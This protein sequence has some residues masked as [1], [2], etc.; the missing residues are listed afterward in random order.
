MVQIHGDEGV[1][2]HIG[3]EPCGVIREDDIESSV[4]EH[5]GQP[6]SREIHEIRVPTQFCWR[7][8]TRTG[9]SSR[10]PAATR[11][12]RRPWHAW[13]L[14]IREPGGLIADH[15]WFAVPGPHR[16]GE[17]PKPVMYGGEKSAWR[18][19]PVP[20]PRSR[21][22]RKSAMRASMTP[23]W[24]RASPGRYPDRSPFHRPHPYRRTAGSPPA[25]RHR[26]SA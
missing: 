12:G 14:F 17:E 1:A 9:A 24:R 4:R 16:E 21:R 26:G 25:Q 7:K 15:G 19:L 23:A 22:G 5:A 10:A 8:A 11:R 2:T 13:T 20:A 6:S 3:P 18:Q